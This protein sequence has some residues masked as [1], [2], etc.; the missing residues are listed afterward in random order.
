MLHDLIVCQALR[1][2]DEQVAR[3]LAKP[4]HELIVAH[5]LNYSTVRY[6]CVHRRL[7]AIFRPKVSVRQ[8]LG[9]YCDHF[10]VDDAFLPSM[11]LDDAPDELTLE[12]SKP[13]ALEPQGLC[14]DDASLSPFSSRTRLAALSSFLVTFLT[15]SCDGPQVPMARVSEIKSDIN[16]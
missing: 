8:L 14:G 6:W 15:K 1:R 5:C 9:T 12:D 7:S 16:S 10:P 2:D 11:H 13:H 4:S 3:S